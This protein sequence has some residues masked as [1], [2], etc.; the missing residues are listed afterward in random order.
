MIFG[1][2]YKVESGENQKFG[3]I[4]FSDFILC[5]DVESSFGVVSEST[6]IDIQYG[7]AC[8]ARKR[9]SGK[10]EPKAGTSLMLLKKVLNN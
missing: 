8:I 3:D 10:Y 2:E 1:T 6:Y 7:D 4:A 5:Y 9:L